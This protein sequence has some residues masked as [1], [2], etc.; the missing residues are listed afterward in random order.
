MKTKIFCILFI[1]AVWGFLKHPNWALAQH[2]SQD[3]A[4]QPIQHTLEL[5]SNDFLVDRPYRS[6]QGPMETKKF[7]LLENEKPEL[8]WIVG[9]QANP[10][11][12]D[13]KK[14]LSQQFLCHSN[15]EF[16]LPN[17]RQLFGWNKNGIAR[18]F[19][20]SQGQSEIHFPEGF[21]I[22]VMSNELM[23][24]ETMLLN[25]NFQGQSFKIKHKLSIHYIRDKDLKK[26]LK[27]L[28][29]VGAMGAKLLQGKDGYYGTEQPDHQMKGMGCS[30]G[31]HALNDDRIT[32][33]DQ[34]GRKFTGHWI[35]KPGREESH[36][37]QKRLWELPFDTTLHYAN[38][39]LHPFAESI[40]LRDL[41]ADKTVFKSYTRQLDQG[42]GLA[43]VDFFSSEEGVPLYRDHEYELITVYNNTTSENQDAMST[44][45]L[46]V[47]DPEFK[48]PA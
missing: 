44:M 8:L 41:T 7:E 5:F 36:T 33:N 20:M 47:L 3:P 18:V 25:M 13:G 10:V 19:L 6:M 23:K 43:H 16:D 4:V 1:L 21:G 11:E 46:Y 24:Y 34:Y 14:S 40:E 32:F 48:K 17:H 28:Y 12:P 42:I 26:P 15:L 30:L 31:M 37:P 38:V 39:H 22:P 29:V 45:L 9:Y 2:S 27:P 35:V